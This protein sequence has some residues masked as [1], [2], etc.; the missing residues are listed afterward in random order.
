[1]KPEPYR[2][3]LLCLIAFV[4]MLLTSCAQTQVYRN[5]QCVFKTQA[6]ASLV[7]FHQADTDLRI[8]GMNHSTPTRAG[9]SVI[10]TAATGATGI[11]TALLTRGLV[12]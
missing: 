9:G 3:L 6:N 11:A 5:G 4:A 12:H 10:G 1:M 8:E 7:V 2:L